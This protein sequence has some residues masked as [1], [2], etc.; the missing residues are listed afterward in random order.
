MLLT[1]CNFWLLSIQ[2]FFG[3]FYD[4][5]KIMKYTLCVCEQSRRIFKENTLFFK[6][7]GP[8]ILLQI[9]LFLSEIMHE[10]GVIF[11]LTLL[12][13]GSNL[14]PFENFVY[15]DIKRKSR[16]TE[17]KIPCEC[18]LSNYNQNAKWLFIKP[19]KSRICWIF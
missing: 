1:A 8:R 2:I 15:H 11:S 14:K 5:L 12:P 6:T 10:R 18:N 7:V 17:W 19:K 4:I 3:I 13:P 16:F 9:Y